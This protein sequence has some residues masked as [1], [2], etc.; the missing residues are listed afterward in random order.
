MRFPH[1]R[2]THHGFTLI[3]LMLVIAIIAVLSGIVIAALS[4][5]RQLGFARDA[6][7]QSA[8][9]TILNALYQYSIDHNGALP[10]SITST[11]Q[12][13]CRTGASDCDDANLDAL[14]GS[15]LSSVPIDPH[16]PDTATGTNYFIRLDN[17]GRLTVSAPGAEVREEISV[18][19]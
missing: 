3:E 8:V 9:N 19:R 15:Y 10:P 12:E 7:R 4:P 5:T 11:L 6:S 18:T 14:S 1:V 13:I 2:N 16:S 17:N